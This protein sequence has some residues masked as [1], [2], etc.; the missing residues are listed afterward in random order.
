MS[1]DTIAEL[2]IFNDNLRE[3]VLLFQRDLCCLHSLEKIEST[4]E[5]SYAMM[6]LPRAKGTV[7]ARAHGL[8]I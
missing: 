5:R 7:T 4:R 1:L 8:T 3:N 2:K 6:F